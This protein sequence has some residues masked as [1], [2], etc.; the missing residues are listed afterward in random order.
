MG[1]TF[2][3]TFQP[4]TGRKASSKPAL[5]TAFVVMLSG[6]MTS[7]AQAPADP[8]A[9]N[10]TVDAAEQNRRLMAQIA[11]LRAQIARLQAP[12]QQTTSGTQPGAMPGMNPASGQGTSTAPSMGM[13]GNKGEMGAMPPKPPMPPKMPMMPPK[14]PMPMGGAGG[15]SMM[16]GGMGGMSG[17]AQSSAPAAPAAAMGMCC[18]GEMGAMPTSGGAAGMGGAA[19]PPAGGMAGMSGAPAQPPGGMSGMPGPS[20]AM[21]G[22]PGASHLY[23]IGSM[24]FFLNHPQHITLT[25]DQRMTLNRLKE[26]AMLDRASAQRRIDQAEQELYGLTGADQPDASRIQT[27]VTEI[28][29]LRADERMKFI[30]AVGEATNVLTHEQ[31]L[32]LMGTMAAGRK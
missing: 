6:G 29:K 3:S 22:Q 20:S 7:F 5:F 24:G 21:P 27:T 12:M 1:K 13:M 31:H 8:M 30:Q 16:E 28:E 23:H 15:M 17:G 11:E 25:Q 4:A 14:P 32:A 2:A 10:A 18:M 9:Q 26:R 19:A